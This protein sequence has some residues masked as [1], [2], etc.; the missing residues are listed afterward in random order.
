MMETSRKFRIYVVEQ[1]GKQTLIADIT[2]ESAPK[3][4]IEA[5]V[6][7]DEDFPNYSGYQDN[8]GE[9]PYVLAIPL[10]WEY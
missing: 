6:I 9:T 3:A 4:L 5:G 7:P 8:D 2:A 1:T 10:L